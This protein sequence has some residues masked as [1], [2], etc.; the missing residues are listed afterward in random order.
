MLYF[1]KNLCYLIP[2][3]YLNNLKEKKS[4][5][6]SSKRFH[7]KYLEKNP[8]LSKLVKIPLPAQLPP[9]PVNNACQTSLFTF[10]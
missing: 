5:N 3:I 8:K 7:L 1:Y 4:V 10:I 9:A 2:Y 6:Y